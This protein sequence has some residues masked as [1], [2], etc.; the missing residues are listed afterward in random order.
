[1]I[2]IIIFVIAII[3]FI[4]TQR[5]KYPKI[6]AVG[7]FDGAPKTGKSTLAIHTAIREYKKV[8]RKTKFI[9]FFRRLFK[10]EEIEMPLL[11]SNIPLKV[12][13]YT[14]V[15]K[16]ILQRK[17]RPRYKSICYL[18]EFSLIAD[19]MTF[20]DGFLNEEIMLF[21][22]LY[23]HE[24]KGGKLIADSQCIADCHYALK[25]VIGQHFYIHN[26]I[27]IPLLPVLIMRV[28]ELVY[29][30]DGSTV[31]VINTDLEEDLKTLIIPKGIWKKFDYCCYS[32]FT[33]D[34]PV[35]DKEV[36]PKTLKAT[37]IVSFREWKNE[38]I[39]RRVK[40]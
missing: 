5:L 1:M 20:K 30:D 32:V 21:M 10:K 25:R 19:S 23:G 24:T 16:K 4:I 14:P 18:G 26:T 27:N 29:S 33:D 2:V 38:E 7:M 37:E 11:Y 31:N 12:K 8:R 13:G 39:K 6:G 15:T 17:E 28:R 9:N 3:A 40:K 34:L 22:K 36:I 35:S